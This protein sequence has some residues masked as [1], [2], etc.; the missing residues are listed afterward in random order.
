MSHEFYFKESSKV[1]PGG[2]NS[3]VR[4]FKQVEQ[5]FPLFIKQGIGS[6]VIDVNDQKYLDFVGS[7]GPMIHGHA[8]P[9]ILNKVKIAIENG[10]S[11]GAPTVAESE[12]AFLIQKAFPS[13]EK[14]RF[15]SSGTEATMTAVRLA[16]GV[17]QKPYIIKF[18]GCYHGHND[19]LLVDCGSGVAT[20]GQTTSDGILQACSTYTLTLP[21]NDPQSLKACFLEYQ[22]QIAGVIV[23]AVAGNMGCIPGT[24][25]F[26]STIQ[27]LCYQHKALFIVDEVMTG[28]RVALG[29]ATE[30]YGLQPDLIT[31]GK[32]VGGGL[33]LAVVGGKKEY[34]AQLAPEG[35]IYHAGTL[36]GN[37]AAVHAGI[38][39]L[40]LLFEKGFHQHLHE[41]TSF[42]CQEVSSGLKSKGLIHSVH[43][44][45]GM[46]TFYALEHPPMNFHDVSYQSKN[47]FN[48]FFDQLLKEGLYWPPSLFESLFISAAH[49]EDQLRWAAESI[50][51]AWDYAIQHNRNSDF[52]SKHGV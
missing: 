40:E 31:L 19:S 14:M 12:L 50:V 22:H 44:C 52:Q 1:F 20:F 48:F 8:H 46:A 41:K 2:V 9:Y 15:T 27:H 5:P 13:M 33:P 17:T 43:Y 36:S 10:L 45:T 23:E 11:F 16:R 51:K 42:F 34:I 25:E 38:S 7:W 49:T 32:I 29:G 6:F 18:I 28:F 39:T 30:L 37:P 26:L 4:A 21:Y 3:P 35:P 24:V 47:W